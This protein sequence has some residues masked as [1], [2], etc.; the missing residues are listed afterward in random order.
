M[1]AALWRYFFP[2]DDQDAIEALIMQVEPES[3]PSLHNVMIDNQ[4]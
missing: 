2:D 3:P 4:S 1:W